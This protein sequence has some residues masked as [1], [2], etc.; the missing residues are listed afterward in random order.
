MKNTQII[1]DVLNKFF[2]SENFDLAPFEVRSKNS[3]FFSEKQQT[4]ITIID[5]YKTLEKVL[6]EIKKTITAL[7]GKPIKRLYII[8][9]VEQDEIIDAYIKFLKEKFN[10]EF[11]IKIFYEDFYSKFIETYK[12][13]RSSNELLD[14]LPKKLT[15][16]PISKS[17]NVF[18]VDELLQQIHSTLEKQNKIN[19]Y[20]QYP[21]LGKTTLGLSYVAK[22]EDDYDHIAY[23]PFMTDIEM[24]FITPF[25]RGMNFKIDERVSLDENYENLVR[26]LS[27]I[28]GKNLLILD[29]V[30]ISFDKLSFFAR[31]TYLEDDLKNWKIILLSNAPLDG[32]NDLELPF[33]DTQQAKKI[34]KF[35]YKK[36]KNNELI[37]NFLR[38]VNNNPALIHLF[39]KNLSTTPDLSLTKLLELL[40]SY[41]TKI[42]R[43]ANYLKFFNDKI[44][45]RISFWLK[46]V[47]AIFEYQLPNFSDLQKR[48]LTFFAAMPLKPYDIETLKEIMNIPE[49]QTDEFGNAI[50]DL[51]SQ[52]WLDSDRDGIYTYSL[53][54]V[55]LHKKLKPTVKKVGSYIEF[56]YR[57][58]S[59]TD[60][61]KTLP[62]VSDAQILLST[63]YDI[64]RQVAFLTVKIAETLEALDAFGYKDY[65]Y[66]AADYLA[67][68][69]SEGNMNEEISELIAHLF[70]KAEVYENAIYFADMTVKIIRSKNDYDP[71]HLADALMTLTY[72]Y[73]HL[74][75]YKLA[76]ITIEQA[77]DIYTEYLKANDQK[78][79]EARKLHEEI[80]QKLKK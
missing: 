1:L 26:I 59:N 50:I 17:Y 15:P 57:K 8:T 5:N 56:L 40:E 41:E 63:I 33:P 43:F 52:G 51:I 32:Y 42:Y 9:N 54:A 2:K 10:P 13:L 3:D 7:S 75:K 55:I 73:N 23:V 30:V 22:Y 29:N 69:Y 60:I 27:K 79:L 80:S 6:Q 71:L 48:I 53:I 46:Y 21:C 78:L 74:K 72:M 58:L 66:L 76:L 35:F 36:E 20:T 25:M 12:D 65:Y 14:K 68:I 44:K 19:I 31:L 62:Y 61:N 49:D 38:K 70:F 39:A 24:S 4:F 77:L 11:D 37:E 67:K 45:T 28:E 16:V 47:L 34:F 18:G 64:N